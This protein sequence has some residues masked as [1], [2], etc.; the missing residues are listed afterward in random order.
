MLTRA[1]D[2]DITQ[3]TFLP[4]GFDIE[5]I[6]LDDVLRE[7]SED[8]SYPHA[9]FLRGSLKAEVDL[10]ISLIIDSL[11]KKISEGTR[12][13]VVSGFPNSME[14]LLEFQRKVS[15]AHTDGTVLTV[16]GSKNKLHI[17]CKQLSKRRSPSKC[18]KPR[19]TLLL[20]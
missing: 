3:S 20:R 9:E 7:K 8:Q 10:P 4:Q 11:E 19:Q 15:I 2:L 13:T 14:Q 17:A 1:G 18:D 6:T 16:V 12:W 5:H